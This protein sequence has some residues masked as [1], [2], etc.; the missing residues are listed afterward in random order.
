MTLQQILDQLAALQTALAAIQ[1]STTQFTQADVDAAVL[2]AKADQA[3]LDAASQA[4][5]QAQ[6]DSLN[7]QVMALQSQVDGIGPIV[8]G[9]VASENARLIGIVKTE[10]EGEEAKLLSAMAQP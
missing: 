4:A 9:A 7:T 8:A 2:Q 3:A 6:I 10:F 1:A 5:L